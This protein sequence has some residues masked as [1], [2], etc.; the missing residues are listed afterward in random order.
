M[1]IVLL[2]I[3]AAAFGS[4][5]HDGR[6]AQPAGARAAARPV[7]GRQVPGACSCSV[8]PSSC[9][10]AWCRSPSPWRLPRR[11]AST[12]PHGIPRRASPTPGG[13]S[14]T[15]CSPRSGTAR[16]APHWRSSSARP[17][18]RSATGVVWLVPLEA[19][20]NGALVTA[21]STG[22]RASSC[23]TS[24][25]AGSASVTLVRTGLTLVVYWA[26]IAV[27]TSVLFSRRDVAS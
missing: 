12:P 6:T 21:V 22:C 16:S 18:W 23:K 3:F 15:C 19:I 11:R 10:P 17:W 4:R 8:S 9:W 26:I 27:G 2:G 14:G 24:T 5:V 13:P 1:G 20:L 25:R 7:P